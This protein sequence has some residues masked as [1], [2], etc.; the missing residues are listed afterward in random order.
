MKPTG[1]RTRRNF[2]KSLSRT[3]LVLSFHDVLSLAIP[4]QQAGAAQGAARPAYNAPARLAPKM[5]SPIAGT[6]LGYQYLDV[7]AASGLHAKTIYGDE[8]RN[9]FLLE[10]TG[11]GVAFFDYDHDDWVDL[12]LVN[13]SRLGGFPKGQEPISRLFKNNRDGTFTDVT[14][15]SR[16]GPRRVGPGLLRGR[17]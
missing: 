5:S 8:H 17:L 4:A 7:A 2:L 6:P 16:R 15:S 14:V 9:R 13:G 11:C 12:F 10:T 3:A 1:G